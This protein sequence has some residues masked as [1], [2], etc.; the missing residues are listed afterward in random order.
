MIGRASVV[1]LLLAL[2][3]SR[4][5]A[6]WLL[7]F[8]AGAAATASNTLDITPA[9]AAPVSIPSIHYEGRSFESP[10]YYG[11]RVGWTPAGHH[12]G[13]EAEFTHAKAIAGAIP[14]ADLTAFQLSHGLNFVLGNVTYRT[15]PTCGGRCTLVARAGAGITIPHV[16]A[17]FREARTYAYEYAG[18]GAQ[19]GIGVE[20]HVSR[21][22]LLIADARLTHARVRADLADGRFAGPFTSVHGDFGI[23]WRSSR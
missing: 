9:S 16:E 6:D 4:A 14:S 1:L 7:A 17:T 3:P 12:L 5:D 23:G 11:Y 13:I 18:F 10:P 22:W 20:V 21:Q 19:G 15:A 2:A 8:Y